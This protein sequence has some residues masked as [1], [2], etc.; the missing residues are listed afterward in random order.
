MKKSYL[1]PEIDVMC[2]L[3][4]GTFLYSTGKATGENVTE[5]SEVD[6]W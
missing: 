6:P 4:E 3:L 5:D 2:V 1:S